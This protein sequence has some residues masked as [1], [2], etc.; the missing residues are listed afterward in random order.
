MAHDT[1]PT[2]SDADIEI[3][4][5]WVRLAQTDPEQAQRVIEQHVAECRWL[6]NLTHPE[7]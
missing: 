5:Q 2:P 7:S 3:A 4:Q 6:R 1:I